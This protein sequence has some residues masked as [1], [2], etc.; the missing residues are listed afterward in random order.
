MLKQEG[1]FGLTFKEIKEILLK[2]QKCDRLFKG[3]T[4]L[5]NPGFN[6]FGMGM[7]ASPGQVYPMMMG[8]T[9][10]MPAFQVPQAP[11]PHT[12]V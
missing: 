9:P 10:Q 1:H 11:A 6:P 3:T 5:P 2:I 12:P 8:I 7:F 4:M